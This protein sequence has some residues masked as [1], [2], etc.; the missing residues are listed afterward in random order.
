MNPP[1]PE[2]DSL[3][4]LL[5]R[6]AFEERFR[7]AVEQAQTNDQPLSFAFLDLDHFLAINTRYGREGGDQVLRTVAEMLR[8]AED[9]Q[10]VVGRYGG[11][12]FVLLF[13]NTEREQAFLA[14][15][16]LR[17]QIASQGAPEPGQTG[18][19]RPYATRASET[20]WR[21]TSTCGC[22]HTAAGR[23][24]HARHVNRSR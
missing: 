16:K 13:P 8:G 17:S 22:W 5:S 24:R 4:G 6:Q 2:T 15:E 21:T 9:V 19:S 1:T 20:G 23:R 10:T 12:E 18:Q 3:T 11:D 7:L 14:L